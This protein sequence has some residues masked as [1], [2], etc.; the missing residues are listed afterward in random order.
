MIHLSKNLISHINIFKTLNNNIVNKT[1]SNSLIFYGN[2]GIGKTTLAFSLINKIYDKIN[3]NIPSSN[4]SNLIYNN[5]HPN[6]RLL[7]KEYDEKTKKLKSYISINQVRNLE[8]FIHQYSFDGSPKFII[9]DS[10]DDLN[11]SSANSL[12]KILEEPKSNIYII[13]ITH[14]LSKLLPTI[15]SRCI[16]FKFST[17]SID[18]FNQIFTNNEK[19]IDKNILKF[20]YDLSEGSPGLAMQMYSENIKEIFDY[21]LEIFKEKKPLS[22]NILQ[23]SN[24]VGAF[25]NDQFSIF[26]FIV[27][28]ILI[29]IIKI[30]LGIDYKNYYVTEL[31]RSLFD[32]SK[33]IDNFLSLKILDYL[34]IHEKDLFVYNL[35]K[36]IFILNIFSPLKN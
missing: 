30:N 26:L 17:P 5:S 10:G 7:V 4:H 18:E 35:D 9:I 12:L 33:H 16:K 27:K 32:L 2:K 6:L 15:R 11:I 31:S 14:H 34:N 36:K 22:S 21:L 8:N 13:I 20:L 25:S 23:L 1:L 24:K 3:V 19:H 29:N 28:F